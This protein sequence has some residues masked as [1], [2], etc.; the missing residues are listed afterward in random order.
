MYKFDIS[1]EELDTLI[2]TLDIEAFQIKQYYAA[3]TQGGSIA[4]LSLYD[5]M[6]LKKIETLAEKLKSI[7]DKKY[8]GLRS[9]S[10]FSRTH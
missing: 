8:E 3:R 2:M 7:Q 10:L 6:R 1:G 4:E 5:D 9:L